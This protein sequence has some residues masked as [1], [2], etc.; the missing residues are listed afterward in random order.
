M[1]LKVSR[2]SGSR[3]S[4]HTSPVPSKKSSTLSYVLLGVR[5]PSTRTT[6]K[7]LITARISCRT[8]KRSFNRSVLPKRPQSKADTLPQHTITDYPLITK[9]KAGTAFRKSL[10]SFFNRLIHTIAATEQLYTHSELMENILIW[11]G[12]LSSAASRP[13]R[14]TSTLIALEVISALCGIAR[15]LLKQRANTLRLRETEQKKARPNKARIN[16][17]LKSANVLEDR[18]TKLDEMIKEWFNT[19]FLHRY[20][21]VDPKIRVDCVTYLSEWIT[22]YSE[23]F[24]DG[25]YLRYLGWVL[26]DVSAP[27]RLE[28]VKQLQKL[29]KDDNKIAGLRQF[30][31][32][33]RARL[34]EIA[35]QDA[36]GNV[37]AAALDLLELLRDKGLLEPDDI[38]TIGNLIF[39]VDARVRKA[40]VAFFVASV[41][42]MYQAKLDDLGGLEAV[43]EVL[44]E[45][46]ED[47]VDKP[48]LAWLRYKSL[49]EL[50]QTYDNSDDMPDTIEQGARS[51][52]EV[53]IASGTDSR[54]R[55]AAQS[56]YGGL[57]VLHQWQLIA[58]Y[59]LHDHSSTVDDRAGTMT[60]FRQA[61][62]LEDKEE[63]VLLDILNVSVQ[64]SLAEVTDNT[65]P[66]KKAK[67]GKLQIREHEERREAAAQQLAALIP[68]LLNKFGA[69]REAATAVLRLQRLLN[70]EIFQQLQQDSTTYAKMLDDINRQFLSH[71]DEGVL[72]AASAALLHA[73]SFEDL[74]EVTESKLQTLWEQTVET[75][76]KLCRGGADLNVRGNFAEQVLGRVSGCVLRIENLSS[77]SDCSEVLQKE[78]KSGKATVTV[79]DLLIELVGRG[80]SG[81]HV[82]AETNA[83]EDALVLHACKALLFYFMWRVRNT[84]EALTASDTFPDA[85]EVEA[86]IDHRNAFSAAL[87]AVLRDRHSADDVSLGVAGTLLDLHV[88]FAT[89]QRFDVTPAATDDPS[90]ALAAT[91]DAQ[92]Q[93]DVLKVFVAVE[94]DYAAKARRKLEEPLEDDHDDPEDAPTEASAEDDDDENAGA[95]DASNGAARHRATLL[96]EERLCA[97]AGK[98][99]LAL[100]AGMLD[101]PQQGRVTGA[102]RR[103]LQRNATRLGGNFKE[104]LAFLTRPVG[105]GKPGA[106]KGQKAR[107]AAA[108]AGAAA[109]GRPARGE[110]ALRVAA[111]GRQRGGALKGVRSREFVEEGADEDEEDEEEDGAEDLMMR[112]FI[113]GEVEEEEA[114]AEERDR[115]GV[116]DEPESVLGD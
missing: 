80:V 78:R 81:P 54:F 35:S 46:D 57:P 113:D 33:F 72:A 56:L 88:L 109:A 58:A 1:R 97:L 31:E 17:L 83:A 70:L 108:G 47:D 27:T 53:L 91:I 114:E 36:E 62:K 14:H 116:E 101:S 77:I 103:R 4:T 110:A 98:M 115:T 32:R 60:Q 3:D 82:D 106:T 55:V 12:T 93:A 87:H 10:T 69:S 40:V 73:K 11:V 71:E 25:E 21:D 16:E 59:L 13:F 15:E 68:K 107:G 100:V 6:L 23:L 38:D 90:S 20:R 92:T 67:V 50:L 111:T 63:V 52:T 66:G 39:D 65:A 95:G 24:F 75:C 9:G 28:V 22:T 94:K 64:A 104:V 86:L 49:A 51:A 37:R 29:F 84:Q 45:A 26:S 76:V 99:V 5:S 102:L 34:V 89:L 112:G 74:E 79:I 42:E 30:T 61:C 43:E 7:T 85:E 48:N 41:D 105:G 19:V 96:A 18:R 44:P 2:Q 8:C